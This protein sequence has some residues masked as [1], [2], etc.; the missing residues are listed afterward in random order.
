MTGEIDSQDLSGGKG[1]CF[2]VMNG[3][4]VVKRSEFIEGGVVWLQQGHRC[5]L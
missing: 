2:L 3:M 4:V 5:E 1:V